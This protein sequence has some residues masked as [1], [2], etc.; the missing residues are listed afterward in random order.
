MT[1]I[2]VTRALAQVK[3]LGDRIA[4]GTSAAFITTVVGDKHASGKPVAEVEQTLRSN[5]QSVKDL[6]AERAKLKAAIVRSN[7]ITMVKIAGKEMTVA[8]A[9]ERKASI[10]LDQQLLST[11]RQQ[12][13]HT[14]TL[15]ERTNVSVQ[16]KLDQL[17]QTAVGKDRKASEDEIE[18]ITDPYKKQNEAK[19]IDPNDLTAVIDAMSKEIDE[20]LLEVDFALSEVNATTQITV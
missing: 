17:I 8:E 1:T 14:A 13:G 6:I 3:Q 2:S 20:F 7:A 11:L 16:Q 4:R 19:A 10:F 12:Q 5:L 9:I 15:V 18:A